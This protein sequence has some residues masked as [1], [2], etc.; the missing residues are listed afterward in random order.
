MK[1]YFT[2]LINYDAYANELLLNAMISAGLPGNS[3]ELMSHL[4]AAQQVWLKR[5]KGLD[6]TGTYLWPIDWQAERIR[7]TININHENWLNY[8]DGLADEDFEKI[9]YYRNMSGDA[10]ES[11]QSDILAH[12]INHGTH[13]R[14]QIG[15]QLK[16]AGT[17][18]LPVTDYIAYTRK[19]NS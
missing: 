15:Q 12:L 18:K 10:M 7:E 19:I 3:A 5:C 2:R 4:L 9:I 16:V 14:A 6:A 8:I 1:T 17:E 13:H 11:R